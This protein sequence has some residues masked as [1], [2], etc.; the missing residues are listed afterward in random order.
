MNKGIDKGIKNSHTN[1]MK[2]AISIPDHIFEELNKLAKENKTSRSQIFCAAVEEYLKKMK[3]YKLLEALNSVYADKATPEEKL[4]RA[5]TKEYYELK[6]LEKN[7][8]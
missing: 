1:C 3:A 4:L 6:V 2:T 8:P 7:K 5:K